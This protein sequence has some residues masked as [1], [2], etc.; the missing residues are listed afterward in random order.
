VSNIVALAFLA[1]V[2]VL[3]FFSHDGRTALLVGLAWAVLVCAGYRLASRSIGA[4][5][6][7]P[8]E[9]DMNVSFSPR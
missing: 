2:V 7:D 6:Q 1:L 8:T 9:R 4:R 3:L 5:G